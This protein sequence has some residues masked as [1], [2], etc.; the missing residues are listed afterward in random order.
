MFRLRFWVGCVQQLQTSFGYR[1]T[2]IGSVAMG[3]PLS[4]RLGG[5]CVW[6]RATVPSGSKVRVC[7]PTMFPVG[8]PGRPWGRGFTM[9]TRFN[10]FVC[11]GAE[12]ALAYLDAASAFFPG[13]PVIEVDRA[14]LHLN[15]TGDLSA[16]AAAFRAAWEAPGGPYFA[17]RLHGELLR[18]LGQPEHALAWYIALLPALDE[19][20]PAAQRETV[21]RR[22]AALEEELG[23]PGDFSWEN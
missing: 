13:D 8:K 6:N 19:N 14:L 17:A 22:I 11:G 15:V 1:H 18:R 4:N 5:F 12:R 21:L 2:G 9:L 23:R 7:L 20:S 16:A 3:R 10:P